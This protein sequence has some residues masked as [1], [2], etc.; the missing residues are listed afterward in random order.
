M[1]TEQAPNI[2]RAKLVKRERRRW[3][4]TQ[5]QLAEVAGVSNRTIQRLESEGASSA[6]TLMAVAQALKLNVK[7]LTSPEE[8]MDT[9]APR[10]YVHLLPRLLVGSD[11]TAIVART[12]HFQIEH[13]DDEDP[14]SVAAMQDVIKELK[15]DIV[16]LFDANSDERIH[17][18][19]ELSLELKGQDDLGY[20]FFGTRRVVPRVDDGLGKF[21]SMATIY[22]S[23]SRSPRIV[24]DRDR[25]VMPA[26][27]TELADEV[28]A[29]R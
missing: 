3:A 20:Y 29:P 8:S 14:R 24:R 21:I 28:T 16:R 2:E 7:Q 10:R 1:D 11:L 22:M 23:H 6:E 5:E 19:Q 26:L 9:A 25:M 15:Q 18:E 27:L 17:V 13:D 4:W 12:E